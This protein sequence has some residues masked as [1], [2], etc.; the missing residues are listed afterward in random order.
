MKLGKLLFSLMITIMSCSFNTI[1]EQKDVNKFKEAI[2]KWHRFRWEGIIEFRH[3]QLNFRKEFILKRNTKEISINIFDSGIF[4][5]SPTPF[6][7]VILDSTYSINSSNSSVKQEIVNNFVNT[8][9]LNHIPTR[10]NNLINQIEANENKIISTKSI[11]IN[12]TNVFFNDQFHICRIFLKKM[13]LELILDYKYN[14]SL[15][16]IKLI[17]D[18]TKLIDIKIDKVSYGKIGE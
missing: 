18:K 6:I 15:S 11:T 1:S 9:N 4:G 5:I 7:S 13:N 17:S 10:L 12:G 14:K 8:T 2:N 3:G 16:N